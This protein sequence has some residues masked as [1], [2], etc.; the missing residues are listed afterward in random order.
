MLKRIGKDFFHLTYAPMAELLIVCL[1]DFQVTL[2][3]TELTVFQTDK[4]RAL[5]AYLTLEG[6]V[7][8]RSE[9]AEF[10]WPG[11]SEESAR[12][13]LR[14]SLFRL[15]QILNDAEAEPPWL[16]LTRQTVQ[17]NPAAPISVDVKIFTRLLEE[18][19]AHNHAELTLCTSCLAR[20]R[21]AVDLYHGDFLA[22]FTVA[23]GDAFEEWRR[24][25]QELLHIQMLDALTILAN[26]AERAG[27]DVGAL[28]YARRQIAIEPWQEAAHRQ[29]MRV[30]AKRGQRTAALAQYNRVRQ[31][32]AEELGVE[33]DSET[34][35]LYEQ[36]NSN[37]FDKLAHEKIT[38]H[39]GKEDSPAQRVTASPPPFELSTLSLPVFAT[40]LI[41]RTQALAEIDTL[42][43]QPGVR[44]LTLVGPGGMGKTRLAVEAA[45]A[46][47]DDVAD[48]IFFVPLA[49][50]SAPA[51]LVGAIASALGIALQG[52]NPRNVLL[53]TLRQK[54]MLLILD[55]F[56]HLLVEGTE[57]ID[58]V[59]ALLDASPGIQIIVTSRQRLKLRSE[60]LYTVPALTFS[61]TATL[62]EATSSAA[63]RLFVQS[64]Q[65]V[66]AG[67]QL[68]ATN[69]AAVLRICQLVQGMPLGLELAATNAGGLSLTAIAD[70]MEQSV[71]ILTVDWRDVPE[72]QRS[73][74]AVFAWSWRLLSREEQR[75][76]CQCAVFR[77]G[78]TFDAGEAVTGASL[79][80]LTRLTDKSLLQWQTTATGDGRYAMHELLRQF[81][82]EELNASGERALV[83]QRHARYYLEFLEARA[84]R[85]GRREP[86]E[87]SVE[88]ASEL[89]NVRLAW[90][91]AAT[92]GQVAE[93]EQATYGWWQYSLLQG[94]EAE[95]R[96]SFALAIDGVRQR[97]ASTEKD[98][99]AKMLGRRLLA[100][101]LAIHADLLFA[102]GRDEEM[103]AQAREAIAL[104]AASG[105][106]E[107]EVFGTYVLGRALQEF[108]QYQAAGDLWRYAV[109][110]YQRY[111]PDHPQSEVLHDAFW[112]SHNWLRGDG[113]RFGDYARSRAHLVQSLLHAQRLGKRRAELQALSGLAHTDYLLFD[114]EAAEP[115]Y[116]AVLDL[117]C[118]VG[119]R[120]IEMEALQ[121]LGDVMRVRGEYTTARTLLEE[122]ETRAE[123]LTLAYDEALILSALVRFYCQ[124]GDQ[125]AAAQRLDQLTQLLARVKLAKECQL[126]GHLAAAFNALNGGAM[127]EAQ[128]YAELANQVNEQGGDILFRLVDSAMIL[129]HARAA[130]E[131]WQDATVAFQQALNA[132]QQLDKQSLAVEAQAGLAQIAL[133]QGDLQD[134][135]AQ[136]EAILPVLAEHPRPGYNNPFFI[137]LIC[138]RVLAANA[139]PR[140][141]TLLQQ[142]YNLLQQDAAR[143]ED[144]K[145]QRFL[146]GVP[147]HR[148][149][150]AAYAEL[151]A[152]HDIVASD[153]VTNT[154]VTATPLYDWDRMP[155]VH[156]FHGR[157]LEMASLTGWINDGRCRLVMVLGIGGVGKSALVAQTVG[158]MAGKVDKVIW[159]SLLNAPPPG[160]ILRQWLRVLSQPGTTL[161][162]GEGEQLRLLLDYLRHQRCLLVLDNVESILCGAS[163]HGAGATQP[164]G[165]LRAGYEGYAPLLQS[166]SQDNH[167]SCLLI[168]SRELPHL[169]G[170]LSKQTPTIQLVALG[171]L[172]PE[173]GQ[174]LLQAHGLL[175]DD[176][177]ALALID[178]YSGNPLALQIV[179]HTIAELYGGDIGAFAAEGTPVFD[180][181]R[182]MLDQQ[183]ARLSS[184]ES[185]LLFWLAIER[186]PL[187]PAMLHSNLVD[188]GSQRIFLEALRALQ[189]RSLLEKVG[190]GFT[191]QNV[192]IEYLTD[193]F[194]E[195]VRAEV[196]NEKVIE[197]SFLAANQPLLNRYA[198]IKAGANESVRQS[199]VRLILRPIAERLLAKVGKPWLMQQA[200]R[201]LAWLR[202][203][204][205]SHQG[206]A[207]GNLLNLLLHLN[208]DVADFDFS[209]LA[210]W[211][212]FLR[213]AYLSGLDFSNADLTGSVFTHRFGEIE[214]LIFGADGDLSVAGV[215][216][217]ALCV[218]RA[219]T[220]ELRTECT[221]EG[222]RPITV[223]WSHDGRMAAVSDANFA[224]H[225]FDV[226][227][228]RRL[229]VLTGATNPIWRICF[230]ADG[231][232]VA[233]GDTS[234]QVTIW[235]TSG[236]RLH[237]L[238]GHTS[239]IT[240]LAFALA[241]DRPE[242]LASG[243]VDS[244][245][246][247]WDARSGEL[248]HRLE[249]HTSEVATLGF[250]QNGKILATASHDCSVRLWDV[251]SG[252]TLHILQRH[253]QLIR[254]IAVTPAG[255]FMATGSGDKL[256]YLWDIQ[257]GEVCHV[258]DDH[259]IVLN[260]VSFSPDEQTLATF[261][262]NGTLCLWDVQSGQ[263]VNAFP[264][265]RNTIRSAD[266]SPDR[267][268]V[269][270]GGGD[271]SLYLWDIGEAVPDS[272][273]GTAAEV[274]CAQFAGI[275]RARLAG[276]RHSI[277]S[278]AFSPA[279]TNRHGEILA[280]G[281]TGQTILLHN[282]H[283]QTQRTLHGHR[284]DIVSLGFNADGRLLASG[285]GDGEVVVWTTA[286]GQKL[287][288]LQGHTNSVLSCRFSPKGA[289]LASGSLD[290]TICLWDGE[291]GE[292]RHTLHGHTNAVQSVTFSPDGRRLISSGYDQCI[293]LWDVCSG[294]L[295]ATWQTPNTVFIS[296][297]VHP[298]A[299]VMAAGAEN[300]LIYLVDLHSG[301]VL[302][303]LAGHS[304]TVNSV[305]FSGD[306]KLLLSASRDETVKLWQVD[307][308]SGRGVCCQTLRA[309]APYSGMKIAGVTGLSEAQK[310]ALKALGAVES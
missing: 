260:H 244:T 218:W 171:G 122:A 291:S 64:V 156:H 11:Y 38:L 210:V 158:A 6:Q 133:A 76:L 211:Q 129:G 97:V 83:E 222:I 284:S 272:E 107:G 13:S 283:T 301:R 106:V 151:E 161:P 103:A 282:L 190:D 262:V 242:L 227:E 237:T 286:N 118:V 168:T 142:G 66:Q 157:E 153:H 126:Y 231:R 61:A 299:E 216:D 228:G 247:L 26:A 189:R 220:G 273:S 203:A 15:R 41:G 269:V 92:Q 219:V 235:A 74:R 259:A 243:G 306:G 296:L 84:L 20:L 88:I 174:A 109:Q 25:S 81:A 199:Q 274:E 208:V 100:K 169:L 308:V 101:L 57:A 44:L 193:R 136:V 146:S 96:Q 309:P 175:P 67:F 280:S 302:D 8:Q 215:R 278:V 113:L 27:D 32:L 303:T 307:V 55:S 163:E 181:I 3:G 128:Y 59:V 9:L 112:L 277:A 135:Q 29:V 115:S 200:Q 223:G 145:R 279:S 179:S 159:S 120:R 184:L 127:Q 104:G 225:L 140:A 267:R 149:L 234:G 48:G 42:L 69:L 266:F 276:H 214:A 152:Q 89:D 70:A 164:A 137:Y 155:T 141:A 117:A 78:F 119:F 251:E 143:L 73:M 197:S 49:P 86:K 248:I 12:N 249:G 297:A 130:V 232:Q 77:G 23:D 131:Q 37:A 293:R 289:L 165:A 295:L 233:C 172:E 36:I 2:S 53:Q 39:N 132:F 144:E 288:T 65:R 91:W 62:A 246:C 258:L 257:S 236:Q 275:F 105:G 195:G 252:R 256:V 54:Q 245:V 121:G 98:E 202:N 305:K 99:G 28:H 79:H 87:A 90:Q 198:L 40:P 310:A 71:D 270:A 116:R 52:A 45:R 10:L 80:L 229:G 108:E 1:G 58:L 304:H 207:A 22:G 240:G 162:E 292:L 5:L 201:W 160:E 75:I 60:Q 300:Q 241:G 46:R 294:Q 176:E 185:E 68:T 239:A 134:A 63:V 82:A 253:T 177:S 139:D 56:E 261:D 206:Y 265:Y 255:N 205:S 21:Q 138:Y 148:D 124:V 4:T 24:I 110:L 7:H 18:C 114:F 221:L 287:H 268:R 212:A 209:G 182:T 102:Q 238:H 217:R 50:I 93:L 33:P 213:G 188:K 47:L 250:A 147:I 263:R 14:Q 254:H 154:L 19:E 180:D 51:A 281:D 271:G 192:I 34:A 95:A 173:A 17:I 186:E 183:V 178:H 187:T 150:V 224:I 35:R 264:V 170:N 94:Q 194:V 125:E 30:L 196:M 204:E 43:Q 72:R 298:A 285:S 166:L 85:L 191:L 167:R 226:A 290:F 230:S 16:L 31:V 111:Q 123:E